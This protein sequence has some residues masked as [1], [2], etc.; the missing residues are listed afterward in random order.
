MLMSVVEQ[1]EDVALLWRV[2]P[3]QPPVV[4]HQQIDAGALFEKSQVSAVCARQIAARIGQTP[5]EHAH[6]P[7]R[8]ARRARKDIE[9]AGAR[10]VASRLRG[11][12]HAKG[13]IS[14]PESLGSATWDCA[15]IE[16]APSRA[17][18]ITGHDAE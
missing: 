2:Q 13:F 9:R 4:E 6:L 10:R 16:E 14:A 17:R 1:L 3:C 11:E 18:T 8:A 12:N 5:A 15:V 7:Q